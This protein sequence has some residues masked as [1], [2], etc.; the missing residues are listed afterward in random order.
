MPTITVPQA[1]LTTE[2][3]CKVLRDGLGAGYNVLPGMAMGRAVVSGPHQGQQDTI[4][5]GKGANRIVKAQITMSSRGGQTV[6]RISPGG[7]TWDLLLNT[8]GVA[9]KVRDVLANSP[10]LHLRKV[11]YYL[12][13]ALASA[14]L[15]SAALADEAVRRR[16]Y[17]SSRPV[18][19]NTRW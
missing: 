11:P 4:L 10:D 14:A 17:S 1:D 12:G 3:V 19:T 13:A 5:V 2:E 15:A 9:R 8:L 16:P 18:A 6:F 7:F